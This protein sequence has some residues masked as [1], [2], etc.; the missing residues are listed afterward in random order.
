MAKILMENSRMGR[1]EAIW[2]VG[3]LEDIKRLKITDW[4]MVNKNRGA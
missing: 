3:I 2:M 1:K 4:I